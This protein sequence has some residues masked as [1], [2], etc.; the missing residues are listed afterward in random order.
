LL[1]FDQKEIITMVNAGRYHRKAMPKK[2]KH[3]GFA[4]LDKR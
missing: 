4:A 1:G 3:P 2:K